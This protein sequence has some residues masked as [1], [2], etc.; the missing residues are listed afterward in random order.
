M[1]MREYISS[2]ICGNASGTDV[3]SASPKILLRGVMIVSTLCSS[4]SRAFSTNSRSSDSI[5]PTRSDNSR[6]AFSSCSLSP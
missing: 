5:F 6:A 1:G 4:K 3:L 2:A